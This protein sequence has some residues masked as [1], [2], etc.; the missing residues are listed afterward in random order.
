MGNVWTI[1][2]E[3]N[4]PVTM[5]GD[6]EYYLGC[7]KTYDTFSASKTSYILNDTS[8]IGVS[9][10]PMQI[11]KEFPVVEEYGHYSD[12][13]GVD[14]ILLSVAQNNIDA[15]LYFNGTISGGKYL[16]TTR[17]EKEAVK[18]S[19]EAEGEGYRL[20]FMD[21]EVKTYIE[22]VD[23]KAAL[24]AEPM[25]NLWSF[26]KEGRTFVTLSNDNEYY[27]GCYKTYD[28][29]SAS[30]T[31]YILNDTSVIGVS[32]FPMEAL[33][34]EKEAK[35]F[36]FVPAVEVKEGVEYSLVV[37]QN[38][39]GKILYFAGDLTGGKYLVSSTDFSKDVVLSAKL[40][41]EGFRLI[42][43]KDGKYVEIV[44]GKAALNDSP[45][46]NLWVLD[47]ETG[48]PMMDC[49][50]TM[51][52]IGCYKTYDT[53]SASKTSYIADTSLIGVSQFPVVLSTIN[54]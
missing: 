49:D 4:V 53:F 31:S 2:S 6:T 44:D 20:S 24:N 52:Y 3:V 14:T 45:L 9:Q 48:I 54:E 1:N 40:E 12:I 51:Y 43:S 17:D 36:V 16:G 25:G 22:I 10:F 33:T 26:N 7:Y 5:V 27:L 13:E 39:I 21:G 30:K 47:S 46:G 19:V 11:V 32:Q 18:V 23:G 50:G 35:A 8:V 29:F 15:V 42:S 41:G 37:E 28:T 34:A 38:N